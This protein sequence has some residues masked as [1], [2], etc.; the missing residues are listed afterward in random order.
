MPTSAALREEDAGRGGVERSPKSG[1]WRRPP[2]YSRRLVRATRV[3]RSGSGPG[4]GPGPGPSSSS[5]TAS[6]IRTRATAP[7]GSPDHFGHQAS[8]I[9]SGEWEGHPLNRQDSRCRSADLV[10]RIPNSKCAKS[11]ASRRHALP[12]HLR[13]S[14]GDF[15]RRPPRILSAEW[16]DLVGGARE[17]SVEPTGF[18]LWAR[19]SCRANAGARRAGLVRVGGGM[20]V[21]AA[22][23]GLAGFRPRPRR[24]KPDAAGTGI[25]V[26]TRIPQPTASCIHTRATAPEV[27]PTASV[28]EPRTSCRGTGGAS[29]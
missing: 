7:R 14:P 26:A 4:S 8:P 10:G 24:S 19:R 2:H 25:A 20:R 22:G 18:A 28:A 11:T 16:E 15:G 12:P 3:G 5:P 6:R 23:S 29:V 17:A 27:R 13:G 21:V 1:A 9:S